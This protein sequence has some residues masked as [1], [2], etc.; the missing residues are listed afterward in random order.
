[1]STD[2]YDEFAIGI[3]GT[4]KT[5]IVAKKE[6][7]THE[8]YEV[9]MDYINENKE[10][11]QALRELLE[12]CGNAAIIKQMDCIFDLDYD[13]WK[14]ISWDDKYPYD[15]EQIALEEADNHAR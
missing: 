8:V 5:G 10:M 4:F 9:L 7:S 13:S 15:W 6:L 2:K 14:E 1:M 3:S 11:K 12:D